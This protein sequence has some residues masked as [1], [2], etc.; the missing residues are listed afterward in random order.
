MGSSTSNDPRVGSG[1]RI[2]RNPLN[3]HLRHLSS[4]TARLHS[5]SRGEWLPLQSGRLS[6][7]TYERS[8]S[9]RAPL[10]AK[11]PEKMYQSDSAQQPTRRSVL[12]YGSAAAATT[13][14]SCATGASEDSEEAWTKAVNGR[15][16]HSVCLWPFEG[17]EWAWDLETLAGHAA[18]L[19]LES[20]ELLSPEQWPTVRKHGLTCAIA[21][22]GMPAPPFM[23]GLN[24][25]R[26]QANVIE[27]T[28]QVMDACS[29][30]GIPS[31]IAVQ[32]LQVERC[33]GS[34]ERRDLSGRGCAE[35]H[36]GVEGTRSLRRG[37]GR[38]GLLG[39]AQH[40]G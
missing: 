34:A 10:K 36:S 29:Q 31:V 33:R 18:E 37:K 13:L 7:Q 39:D 28:K 21:G 38:H 11:E 26:Y 17:S 40:E 15:I 23:K 1:C 27:T 35:H 6:G 19:G 2:R 8:N 5:E 16:R 3:A 22:N 14:A 24:N 12:G 4:G 9:Q 25:P 20:V 32:R 30:E